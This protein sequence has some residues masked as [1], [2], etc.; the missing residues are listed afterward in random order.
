M[1]ASRIFLDAERFAKT[2]EARNRRSGDVG[3]ED[4][5]AAMQPAQSDREQRRRQRLTDAALARHDG[6]DVLEAGAPIEFTRS[7][8]HGFLVGVHDRRHAPRKPRLRQGCENRF[9]PQAV[10]GG[11]LFERLVLVD[12]AAG[13][14]KAELGEDFLGDG[15][16]ADQ[17]ADIGRR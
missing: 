4:A 5:D 6:Y 10:G 7:A 12:A 11:A 3:V 9:D 13:A 16:S 2:E 1:R 14:V 17:L 15:Q 8:P